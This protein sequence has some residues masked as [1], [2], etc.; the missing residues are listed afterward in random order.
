MDLPFRVGHG[1]E[2]TLITYMPKIPYD[3]SDVLLPIITIGATYQYRKR[4]NLIERHKYTKINKGGTVK[5]SYNT[6]MHIQ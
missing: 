6:Y 1:I 5:K 3:I 4:L 2:I